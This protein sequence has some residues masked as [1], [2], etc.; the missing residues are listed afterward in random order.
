MDLQ[1][2][3]LIGFA[4]VFV[5]TTWLVSAAL[6]AW[7]V[8]ARPRLRRAGARAERRAA[9]LTLVM[10]VAIGAAL[11]GGLVGL[12][13]IGP[14]LGFA[15]HCPA[16][17]HHLHLCLRHGGEWGVRIWAIALIA[18]IGSLVAARLLRAAR[19]SWLIAGRLRAVSAVSVAHRMP[20]GSTCV[21]APSRELFCFS[22][23]WRAPRIFLSDAVLERLDDEQL[24]AVLAHERAHIELGDLWRAVVLR[25]LAVLGAPG[26][27]AAALSI[28]N[29]ASER[30]CDRIAA[31]AVGS[32]AAVASSIL[33]FARARGVTP[34]CAFAPRRDRLI[35]RVEA[36]LAG[37]PFGAPEARQLFARAAVAYGALAV[38]VIALA[39]PIHHAIETLLG[40][41]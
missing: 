31:D 25:G 32:P 12:S 24:R 23:G 27:A 36:V 14:A 38:A 16:H 8:R 4:L 22:V 39:D 11:T 7:L 9:A 19:R 28:W 6:C 17:D 29:E 30:L 35:E 34:G 33:T 2:G 5:A 3:S 21:R 18:G 15:D 10:P 26:A 1:P 20:D 13:A 40:R 41:L 37:V